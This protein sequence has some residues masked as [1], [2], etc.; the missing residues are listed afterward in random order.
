M[1]GA[2]SNYCT[3][4]CAAAAAILGCFDIVKRFAKSLLSKWR[5]ET[6]RSDDARQTQVRAGANGKNKEW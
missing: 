3:P 2:I 5:Y 4:Q 1:G 6:V